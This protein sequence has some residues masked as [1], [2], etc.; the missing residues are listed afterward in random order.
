MNKYH[1]KNY[2][3]AVFIFLSS[4]FFITSSYALTATSTLTEASP[5][6]VASSTK[7]ACVDLPKNLYRYA[8]SDQVKTL[9][10][11]LYAS[12]FLKAKPN[13]Y[14]GVGT[15]SA[16]K[17][18]QKSVGLSQVGSVGPA[19]RKEIKR[20]S[21]GGTFSSST[22]V[23]TPPKTPAISTLPP[24]TTTQPAKP[25]VVATST[26]VATSSA[27]VVST[28]PKSELNN[29]TRKEHLTTL[30]RA[31][32]Q[33]FRDSRGVPPV[34]ETEDPIELCVAPKITQMASS[35]EVAILTTA[36]SPCKNVVDIAYL[37]P[38]YL[39]WIPRDPT[40]ATSSV[41]TGYTITRS[42][43]NDI[44]L[45][46]KSAENKAIIK[47]SCNFNA[48]CKDITFIDKEVLKKP[49]ITSLSRTRFL[50]D[51]SMVTPFVIYG[52]NFGTSSKI[53]LSSMYDGSSYDLGS[54]SATAPTATTSKMSID[55][56]LFA[57]EFPCGDM[58]TRKI[59]LGDYMLTL[60]SA[61]GVS[62][63]TY[64]YLKGVTTSTITL[65]NERPVLPLSVST[66]VAT[67]TLSSSIPLTLKTLTLT[68]SST[69]SVLPGKISNFT[70]K[71]MTE[72]VTYAGGA[73]TFSF[74]SA[75]LLENYSKIYDIYVN[76][77]DLLVK[78]SG[79]ITY[80]G[81]FLVRDEFTGVDMEIPI[82]PFM[83]T[84]S[85]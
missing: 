39:P 23:V 19:T 80:S 11:F 47:M 37:Y 82:K 57:K 53:T 84:V 13:G 33:Y 2:I 42:P 26:P 54:Y 50:R 6:K 35:A 14:F 62:N 60:T 34:R 31:L 56:L 7:Y 18:F 25:P 83:F 79:N 81:K 45:T 49:E 48:N 43:Y 51:A 63:T 44:T 3:V 4:L 73:G 65:Q 29:D 24:A 41:M 12:S 40:L 28:K 85:Y 75:K 21:C 69:S 78:D 20:I 70:A 71:E 15:F 52:K 64:I 5:Q 9:Q 66:K 16:V 8:E 22:V 72:A 1:K 58:C 36:D 76:V 38:T 68:A 30:L 61:G 74:G 32:S 55:G 46:A 77:G 27:V 67:L 10:D 17:E 59:P